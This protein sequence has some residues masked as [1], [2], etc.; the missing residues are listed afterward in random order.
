[1]TI[2]G[3]HLAVAW[4][5]PLDPSGHDAWLVPVYVFQ[6][7]GE[8]AYPVSGNEV[9][10]LAVASQ[11]VAAPPS[12]TMPA[13]VTKPGTTPAPNTVVTAPVPSTAGS[14]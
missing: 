4:A 7:T 6:L 5:W 1:V 12:T 13:G 2:T 3:V 9:P 10:V 8:A 11:Y 14:K